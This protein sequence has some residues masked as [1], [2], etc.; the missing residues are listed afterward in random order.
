M[1]KCNKD[2]R[3]IPRSKV[4]DG[5]KLCS[6][7]ADEDK[8][9]CLDWK[10]SDGLVKCRDNRKCISG[11]W[12]CKNGTKCINDEHV[13]DGHIQC[14][15][16]S[17]EDVAFCKSFLCPDVQFRW[18]RPKSRWKCKDNVTC[19]YQTYI[20][21]GKV[22]CPDKECPYG[23]H[24]CDNMQCIDNRKWC[25]GKIE[26]TDG[27]DEGPHCEQ[28]ECDDRYWKC[29]NNRECIK[30][31][32]VCDRDSFKGYQYDSRRCKDKSDEHNILCGYCS[33]EGL[34]P[35]RDG[36]GCVADTDV[37]DGRIN[38][39]D[40]SDERDCLNIKCFPGGRKCANKMECVLEDDICDGIADCLDGSDE[41]CAAPCLQG[42][43]H[44]N[45]IVKKCSEDNTICFPIEMF[46]N[47]VRD[48]PQG[49]DETDSS[50]TCED[51]GLHQ[52]QLA[53]SHLCVYREWFPYMNV[54]S[55]GS[56]YPTNEGNQNKAIDEEKLWQLKNL[57][58]MFH[59][60]LTEI[61]TPRTKGSGITVCIK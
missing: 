20:K 2:N 52:L 59:S 8:D 60:G 40:G 14:P 19:V 58:G 11:K 35:C 18:G 51:W 9:L 45:T 1:W 54:T 39:K 33:R 31:D 23:S 29:A 21:N 16:G 17:D 55:D 50:C 26:C 15:D 24:A 22:Y 46:C 27:S 38:C 57:S 25:D 48:C 53:G 4:C 32:Y 5:K 37:C 10:C 42:N 30:I 36:D 61:P 47:N 49:S 28:W 12:R 43:L 6:D 41:L 34:W 44:H 13:C 56:L 7:G 3:C